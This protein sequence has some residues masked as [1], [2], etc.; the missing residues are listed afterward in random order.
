MFIISK[1]F[2]NQFT[3]YL[4]ILTLE[5]GSRTE[6]LLR[7]VVTKY[8]HVVLYV[9]QIHRSSSI[10]ICYSGQGDGFCDVSLTRER[11][12]PRE[13]V[14]FAADHHGQVCKKKRM[15]REP[16]KNN[17]ESGFS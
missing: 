1:I 5:Q 9:G 16:L 13:K 7:E 6:I 17:L 2:A 11:T 15:V 14:D 3:R 8:G 10:V 4:S 12:V